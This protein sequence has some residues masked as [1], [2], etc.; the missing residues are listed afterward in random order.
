MLGL[1]T[2]AASPVEALSSKPFPLLDRLVA[3]A[4]VEFVVRLY[5]DAYF[6]CV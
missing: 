5:E 1:L 6:K 4:L 2:E 3:R